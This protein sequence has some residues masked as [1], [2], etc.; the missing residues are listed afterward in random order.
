MW[1][2][3]WYLVRW[4]FWLR[5]ECVIGRGRA[6]A[7]LYQRALKPDYLDMA[8]K[9][10]ALIFILVWHFG[11]P[12]FVKRGLSDRQRFFAGA[13]VGALVEVAIFTTTGT[14]MWGRV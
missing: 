8:K 4:P 12:I 6:S 9:M 2:R 3:G 13:L 14:S 5:S 7:Q 1:F 11:Q 10:A